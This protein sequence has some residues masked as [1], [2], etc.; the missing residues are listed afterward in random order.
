MNINS[1]PGG[2]ML[3]AASSLEI[4]NWLSVINLEAIYSMIA[5]IALLW[6]ASYTSTAMAMRLI[7]RHDK[8]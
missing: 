8:T 3:V 1:T 5:A 4:T 6:I 2:L 7:K